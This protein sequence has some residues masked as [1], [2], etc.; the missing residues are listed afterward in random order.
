MPACLQAFAGEL[1]FSCNA[2]NYIIAYCKYLFFNSLRN[3]NPIK[4][5]KKL[6]NPP[7]KHEP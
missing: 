2:M 3:Y 7:Q 1:V 4:T 6:C 5:C